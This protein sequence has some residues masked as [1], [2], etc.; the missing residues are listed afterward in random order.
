MTAPT[1]PLREIREALEPFA[2][3]AQLLRDRGGDTR[4]IEAPLFYCGTVEDP[5][6]HTLTG[7]AF[8]RARRALA[9]IDALEG[10]SEGALEAGA[11]CSQRLHGDL[12]S[13]SPTGHRAGRHRC[14][15]LP[16]EGA[17]QWIT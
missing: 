7:K 13:R 5:Q 2:I 9:L 3:V 10:V 1:N 11:R 12:L 17:P 6:S 4:W 14:L 15:P 8:D 16:P